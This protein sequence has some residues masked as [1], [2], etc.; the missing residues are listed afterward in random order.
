M[1]IQIF[2]FTFIFIYVKFYIHLL[3]K[4]HRRYWELLKMVSESL[5][6]RESGNHALEQEA[7]IIKYNLLNLSCCFTPF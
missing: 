6:T 7:F 4:I 1:I 3:C 5:D 2:S